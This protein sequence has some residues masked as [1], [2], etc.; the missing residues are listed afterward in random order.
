MTPEKMT[1]ESFGCAP[2]GWKEA[3]LSEL[4]SWDFK[5]LFKR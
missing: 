1:L 2:A 3:R 5:E 4:A